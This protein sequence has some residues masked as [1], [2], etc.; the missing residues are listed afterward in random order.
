MEK[1]PKS[2]LNSRRPPLAEALKLEGGTI[3]EAT[4]SLSRKGYFE[5]PPGPW[6]VGGLERGLGRNSFAVLDKFEDVVVET[7]DQELAELIVKAVNAYRQKPRR[8][9][10][11][12]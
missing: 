7:R 4:N 9:K 5:P 2:Y 10:K 8:N 11:T 12:D 6:Q 3:I 1:P